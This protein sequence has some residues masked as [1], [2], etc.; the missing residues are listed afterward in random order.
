MMKSEWKFFDL[1][2][3][4]GCMAGHICMSAWISLVP[5]NSLATHSL[6]AVSMQMIGQLKYEQ[7]GILFVWIGA[8]EGGFWGWMVVPGAPGRNFGMTSKEGKKLPGKW[9][10]SCVSPTTES[11]HSIQCKFLL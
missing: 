4:C 1:Q 8:L 10:K 9:L 3:S 6:G 11:F 2:A 5:Y 7:I